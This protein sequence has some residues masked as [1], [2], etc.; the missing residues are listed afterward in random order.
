[1]FKE[2][3]LAETWI[4]SE[5]NDVQS[6]CVCVPLKPLY[7]GVPGPPLGPGDPGC[8]GI[9]VGI[10]EPEPASTHTQTRTYIN[11]LEVKM[12]QSRQKQYKICDIYRFHT[13]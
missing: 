2:S 13:V 6:A 12:A 11:Q 10:F 5:N 4:L 8:P 7:P 1:M 9:L 3:F